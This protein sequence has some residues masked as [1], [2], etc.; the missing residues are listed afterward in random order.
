M[1][2]SSPVLSC[3]YKGHWAHSSTQEMSETDRTVISRMC[4]KTFKRSSGN[5]Y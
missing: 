4:L 2:I 3:N 1:V 5:S